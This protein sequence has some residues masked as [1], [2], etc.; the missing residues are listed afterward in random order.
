[1]GTDCKDNLHYAVNFSARYS[2]ISYPYDILN[3]DPKLVSHSMKNYRLQQNS[4]A[5][6]AASSIYGFS[7][8][9]VGVPRLQ[10]QAW[11]IGA[12]EYSNR[13]IGA[14]ANFRKVGP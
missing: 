11:D 7:S 5:I 4:P 10:G 14:P 8:D 13:N 9:I 12:Y 1:M 3:T 6:K 2:A